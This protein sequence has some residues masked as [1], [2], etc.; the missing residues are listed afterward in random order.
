MEE[1]YDESLSVSLN[2]SDDIPYLD[3]TSEN[4]ASVCFG[5]LQNVQNCSKEPFTV[6]AS[7]TT[8][9]ILEKLAETFLPFSC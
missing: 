5:N 8:S 9:F 1:V 7:E 4:I 2:A 6:N 3:I